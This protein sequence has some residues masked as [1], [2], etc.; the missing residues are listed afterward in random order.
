MNKRNM[1]VLMYILVAGL[2][3]SLPRVAFGTVS[4][5]VAL[6]GLSHASMTCQSNIL[7]YSTRAR[8]TALRATDFDTDLPAILAQDG[9]SVSV[10][11]RDSS[12]ID[13]LS[14]AI[15]SKYDQLWFISTETSPEVLSL[16]EVQAIQD[17]HTA[18]KGIMVISDGC[19]YTGPANQFS[20]ALGVRFTSDRCCDCNHCGGGIGCLISTSG[21]AP[22]EIWNGVSEIQ[23]NLNEGDLAVVSTGEIIATDNNINMVA[24]GTGVGG[25]VAWDAT[26]YRFSDATG[27]PNLAVTYAD[28][29]RYVR[30]LANWLGTGDSTPPTI[31][32]SMNPEVLWPP[33][34]KMVDIT[35]TVT[36]TDNC[37]ASPTFKLIS[38]ESNEPDNGKGDGNTVG[39]ISGATFGTPDVAFQ[40]RAE[41]SG[42]GT[43]RIY[44]IIYE[45]EDCSMNFAY[46]TVQVRVP[47]DGSSE[48]Q[49]E[50]LPGK[51]RVAALLPSYPNPFNPTTTV[52]YSLTAREYVSLQIFDTKGRLV[53]T[54]CNEVV[55]E[56]THGVIWNGRDNLGSQVAAGVYFVRFKAGDYQVTRKLV[57][58]R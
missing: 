12:S 15:L 20:P 55:S 50:D 38:V 49:D 54:L 34:H 2:C 3:L 8:G 43:G 58:V 36:V 4:N 9:H 40:L 41:R 45:A 28:N 37:C 6:G 30:N 48:E 53:R 51:A 56:G 33:N 46:D 42:N 22:H 23:A 52:S 31:S 7:V 26:V 57:M 11:D 27:H 14:A 21:F 25:R 32:V 44:T 13:T 1:F 35:A 16:S 24:V 5:N 39:D 10:F 17:F 29:A 19:A 18:G 47:H